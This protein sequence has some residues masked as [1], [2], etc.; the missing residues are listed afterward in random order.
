MQE[1]ATEAQASPYLRI[2]RLKKQFGS[3]WALKD[4]SLETCMIALQGPKAEA[5]LQKL[6]TQNLKQM[7]ARTALSRVKARAPVTSASGDVATC[8]RTRLPRTTRALM[9]PR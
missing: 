4:I 5:I 3:F 2:E 8:S 7:A 9:P 1:K 6:T